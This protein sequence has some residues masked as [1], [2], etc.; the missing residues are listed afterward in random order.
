[1]MHCQRRERAANPDST[2]TFRNQ[3][4]RSRMRNGTDLPA[5]AIPL[6]YESPAAAIVARCA[7]GFDKNEN[8]VHLMEKWIDH[9]KNIPCIWS[10]LCFNKKALGLIKKYPLYINW[11]S[12]VQNESDEAVDILLENQQNIE[13]YLLSNFFL[14]KSIFLI[15]ILIFKRLKFSLN[16]LI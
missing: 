4:P 8:A 16:L 7:R 5:L 15:F 3:T 12:L 11:F 14:R 10:Q 1:M 2:G 6:L 9:W 13:L